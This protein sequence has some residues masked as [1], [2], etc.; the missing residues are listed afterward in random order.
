MYMVHKVVK[1][2]RDGPKD[3]LVRRQT[4]AKKAKWGVDPFFFIIHFIYPIRLCRKLYKVQR[5][6]TKILTQQNDETEK[7]DPTCG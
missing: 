4:A 5:I 3:G 7:W 2:K 6:I 1:R